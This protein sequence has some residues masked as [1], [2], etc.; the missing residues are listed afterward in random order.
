[1]LKWARAKGCP[2]DERT[3]YE[4]AKE[5][6]LEVFQWARDNGCPWND[7]YT[8]LAGELLV[9]ERVVSEEGCAVM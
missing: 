2:W 1:M 6:H 3:C 8:D 4:A 7:K 9:L 5:G